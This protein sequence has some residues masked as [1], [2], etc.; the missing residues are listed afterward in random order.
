MSPNISANTSMARR[1]ATTSIS[2][3]LSESDHH[4]NALGYMPAAV[5]RTR[6]LTEP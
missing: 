5:N 4:D 2:V 1:I 3:P 6:S